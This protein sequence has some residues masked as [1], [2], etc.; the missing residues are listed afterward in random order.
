MAAIPRRRA[1]AK[2]NGG[3]VASGEPAPSGG[4]F[5]MLN[6]WNK[7]FDIFD[8]DQDG[9][10]SASE[11]GK[12]LTECGMSYDKRALA[13][14]VERY[15]SNH[16]GM[17][18]FDEFMEMMTLSSSTQ[19]GGVETQVAAAIAAKEQ[20]DEQQQTSEPSPA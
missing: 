1:P 9:F 4:F 3:H 14:A 6:K 2:L 5:D 16:N 11:I 8:I 7:A 15:D 18:D 19:Q 12:V 10:I 13:E 17:I 20:H